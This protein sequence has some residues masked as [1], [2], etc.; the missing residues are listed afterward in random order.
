LA[1]Y[2][3]RLR[4]GPIVGKRT[5]GG[6]TGAF[7]TPDLMDGGVFEV[8]SAA[9][10]GTNGESVE[11]RGIVPDVEVEFDPEQA[12]RGRDPQLEEAI[13]LTLKELEKNPAPSPRRPAYTNRQRSGNR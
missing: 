1:W 11:N 9:I 5:W 4:L 10:W 7:G 13:K 8:P 2:F 6:L 3:R 12:R